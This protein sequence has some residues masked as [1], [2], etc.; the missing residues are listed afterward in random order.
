MPI[1]SDKKVL[2]AIKETQTFCKVCSKKPSRVERIFIC[3]VC[4]DW[5]CSDC[6]A[7]NEHLYELATKA[8]VKINFVCSSCEEQLPKVRDLLKLSSRQE[9]MEKDIVQIK[10]DVSNNTTLINQQKEKSDSTEERLKKVEELLQINHLDE[11]EEFPTLPKMN[12]AAK[13][14]AEQLTSQRETTKKLNAQLNE[15]RELNAEEKR[16]AARAANLIVYGLPEETESNNEL[17][18]MKND[19]N[20]LQDLL[21][22]RVEIDTKDISDIRRL[23]TKKDKS[24]PLRITFKNQEKRKEILTNN[25]GL[26]ISDD[27]YQVC[28]CK[29]YPGR[30][31]HVNI[32]NDKTRQQR[33]TEAKLREELKER[34]KSGENIKIKQ[35]KIVSRDPSNAHPRWADLFENGF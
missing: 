16:Q 11:D 17:E 28:P 8:T 30:H 2:S 23:G 6:S 1:I 26:I 25:L 33:E 31:V 13:S 32:T 14:L 15:Q 20:N 18:Q 12:A 35:G 34:R 24:R 19:F 22:D 4:S 29:T 9:E 27:K 21:S 3:D 5:L 10:E 7:V